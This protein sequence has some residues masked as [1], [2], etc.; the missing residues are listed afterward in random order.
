MEIAG[1]SRPA[2]GSEH[3][4]SR[5]DELA[6]K[7]KMHGLRVGT[8]AYL[9]SMLQNNPETEGVRIFCQPPAFLLFVAESPF[10]KTEFI[11]AIETGTDN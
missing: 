6:A 10:D 1:T 7:P 3:L 11:K 8:A 9:A 2:S 4:I 5:V